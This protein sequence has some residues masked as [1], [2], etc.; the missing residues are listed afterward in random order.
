MRAVARACH[1]HALLVVAVGSRIDGDPQPDSDLD[2]VVVAED[3]DRLR[4]A[5]GRADEA[6]AR[7]G[8]RADVMAFTTGA[9]RESLHD[10]A[11]VWHRWG[12]RGV[13]LEG[14]LAAVFGA[15]TAT[16]LISPISDREVVVD[17]AYSRARRGRDLAADFRRTIGALEAVGLP[18]DFSAIAADMLVRQ[19]VGADLSRVPYGI[20][21]TPEP[22][23]ARDR[24]TGVCARFGLDPLPYTGLMAACPYPSAGVWGVRAPDGET[25]RIAGLIDMLAGG[26]HEFLEHTTSGAPSIQ[27]RPDGGGRQERVCDASAKE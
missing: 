17:L 11:G 23:D 21:C 19:A 14:S 27:P 4:I 6:C 10:D 26:A 24:I 16:W 2:I 25:D 13:V 7:S 9:A 18:F 8:L 5:A 15:E 3:V 1:R 20:D 22:A 12:S